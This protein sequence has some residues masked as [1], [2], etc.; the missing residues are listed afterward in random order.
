MKIT[1]ANVE[2]DIIDIT[3]IKPTPPSSIDFG[4][5]TN[6]RAININIVKVTAI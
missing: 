6:T 4:N 5:L 2:V 3:L 1:N